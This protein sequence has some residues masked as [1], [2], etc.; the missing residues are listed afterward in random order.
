MVTST[1]GADEKPCP[2]ALPSSD[3]EGLGVIIAFLL[4]AYVCWVVIVAFYMLGL[5]PDVLNN[6]DECFLGV[7]IRP[8]NRW[9]EILCKG[10]LVA[11]TQQLV[12][13]IAILSSGFA[14]VAH[15]VLM[16]FH[17]MTYL[18]WTSSIMHMSTLTFLP[19][20]F[21]ESLRFRALRVFSMLILLIMLCIAIF[22]TTN[23]TWDDYIKLGGNCQS[24][25]YC[26]MLN[27]TV[28]SLWHVAAQSNG[29]GRLSTQGV[30]SY[31]LLIGSSIWKVVTLFHNVREGSRRFL[32][33]PIFYLERMICRFLQKRGKTDF[34]YCTFVGFYIF[35]LAILDFAGSFAFYLWIVLT[36]L[37]WATFQLFFPRMQ[38]LPSCVRVQLDEWNFGQILPLM[39]LLLP[40]YSVAEY[41]FVTLSKLDMDSSPGQQR[42]NDGRHTIPQKAISELFLSLSASQAQSQSSSTDPKIYAAIYD[43][44][45]FRMM[46]AF[47]TLAVVATTAGFFAQTTVAFVGPAAP[48]GF[49]TSNWRLAPAF[50]SAG[51]ALIVLFFAAFIGSFF[52]KRLSQ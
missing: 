28:S 39:L 32:R 10:V 22:P 41:Y 3:V 33:Q 6:F 46:L 12:M 11:G 23:F 13:G 48:Y 42:A 49:W 50:V 38:A 14:G 40:L 29:R 5:I 37:G 20:D 19:S 21:R 52:S 9:G 18:A 30:V 4:P 7:R 24:A 44:S 8:S 27:D 34:R 43:T 51:L 36:C 47:L 26:P 2:F 25:S 15:M 17:V 1:T 35:F 31:L 45:Y 16:D